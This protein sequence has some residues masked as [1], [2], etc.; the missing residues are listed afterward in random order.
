MNA[1]A[2][3]SFRLLL[4]RISLK[5][6][7]T[8][9]MNVSGCSNAAKCPPLVSSLKYTTLANLFS[10]HR[11]DV[12]NIS[13]GKIEQPTGTVTGSDSASAPRKLSQYRRAEDAAFAGS[14]YSITLSSNS[15]R[16]ST[17]SGWPSLALQDQNFSNI[18]V[19]CP[20]GESVSP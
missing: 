17:F 3:A 4:Y 6:L 15:S 19:S 12:R 2:F 20:A 10:A 5:Q 16:V 18:Q 8:S 7:R 13:L 14:Q 11:R 9:R 1:S